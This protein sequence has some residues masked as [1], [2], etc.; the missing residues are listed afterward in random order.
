M[1]FCI[2]LLALVASAPLFAQTAKDDGFFVDGS[3]GRNEA[4]SYWS[5]N[6]ARAID[7]GYRW[8]WFSID[9]GYVDF[10]RATGSFHDVAPNAGKLEYKSSIWDRGIVADIGGRWTIGTNWYYTVKAGLNFWQESSRLD[11]FMP[12]APPSHFHDSGTSWN[13]GV[14]IGYQFNQHLSAGLEYDW[15]HDASALSLTAEYK[16]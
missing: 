4:S 12:P 9:L 13:A 14:G 16:F 10:S 1:K 15:Y 6:T 3:I 11:Y 2:P 8:G 5:H 7:G